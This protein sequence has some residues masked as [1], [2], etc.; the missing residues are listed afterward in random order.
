MAV[1]EL[2]CVS[3][4]SQSVTAMSASAPLRPVLFDFEKK[5]LKTTLGKK[6]KY[7]N[8]NSHYWWTS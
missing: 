5:P 3:R 2:S 1:H 4:V 8:Y 6:N 7:F